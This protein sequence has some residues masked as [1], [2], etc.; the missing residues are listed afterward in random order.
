MVAVMLM[1]VVLIATLCVVAYTLAVYAPPLMLGL[2]AA[3]FSHQ[4]DSGLIGAS[5]VG[6][7]AAGVA[8]GLLAVLHE[9][10]RSQ[11]LCL[12]SGADLRT[13]A[14]I[15]GYALVHGVTKEAV[16][17]EI[18]RQSLCV[19]GS[20]FVGVSALMRA[21]RAGRIAIRPIVGRAFDPMS[22][23]ITRQ[24]HHHDPRNDE[25]G[26]KQSQWCWRSPQDCNA[27]H[28]G[29][30]RTDSRPDGVGGTERQRFHGN[31]Q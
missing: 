12:I 9:T 11:I 19:I 18:W 30:Y 26:G 27:N 16:L 20:G 28:E 8:F 31:R 13:S 1:S 29:A 5:L 17:S 21:R 24:F 6:L 22:S 7:L 4:T 3:Q 10:L 23:V 14:A 2:S 25:R 15:A